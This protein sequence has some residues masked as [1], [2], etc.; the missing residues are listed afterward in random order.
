MNNDLT[1]PKIQNDITLVDIRSDPQRFP[2]L[3]NIPPEIA[4]QSLIQIVFMAYMY[5]GQ[6]VVEENISFVASALMAELLEENQYGTRYLTME[7]ITRVVKKAALS[8]ETFGISVATLYS[9]LVKYCSSEGK[10]ADAQ[11]KERAAKLRSL[12]N[13]IAAPMIQEYAEKLIQKK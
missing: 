4:L 7:E 13:E 5:R 6:A 2:R 1:I 3:H 11:A 10:K 8:S 9:A 12:K